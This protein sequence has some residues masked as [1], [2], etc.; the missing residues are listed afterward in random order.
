MDVELAYLNARLPKESALGEILPE[1]W[2][3]PPEPETRDVGVSEAELV[4]EYGPPPS[5]DASDDDGL[6]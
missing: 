4:E 3:I 1:D 2:N 6:G 5:W